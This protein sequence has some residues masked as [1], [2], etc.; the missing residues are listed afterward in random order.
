MYG[1]WFLL[2]ISFDVGE[3]FLIFGEFRVDLSLEIVDL[4]LGLCKFYY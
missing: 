2:L 4:R 3:I 1:M